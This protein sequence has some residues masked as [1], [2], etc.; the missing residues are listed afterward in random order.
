MSA[1]ESEVGETLTTIQQRAAL[2]LLRAYQWLFS[3]M[4]AGSCRFVPSCSAYAAEA[5]GRFGVV[6]GSWLALRRLARC[7]PLAAHGFDPVPARTSPTE[8]T[9]DD[10]GPGAERPAGATDPQ[11]RQSHE[12][13]SG[14]AGRLRSQPVASLD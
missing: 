5:I 13:S 4:F 2:A 7:R 12:C 3:P 6:H 10:P 14:A 8:V 11:P 9:A 1:T